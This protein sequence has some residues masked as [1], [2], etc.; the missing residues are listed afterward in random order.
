MCAEELPTGKAPARRAS[1]GRNA[2][3][4]EDDIKSDLKYTA[5]VCVC[6]CVWGGG[7]KLNPSGSEYGPKEGSC[8]RGYELPRCIRVGNFYTD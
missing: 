3:E 8:E 7:C 1:L 6:V 4:F 2:Y 5:C